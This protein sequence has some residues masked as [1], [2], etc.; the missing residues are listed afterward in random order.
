MVELKA[1]AH[2]CKRLTAPPFLKLSF[3]L[4]LPIN[5]DESHA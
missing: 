4:S 5:S 1:S 2:L 3:S